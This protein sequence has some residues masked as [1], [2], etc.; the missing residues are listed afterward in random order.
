MIDWHRRRVC[1]TGGTGFL[2]FH[3][4]RQLRALGAQVRV[5]A[6]PAPP[7]HPIHDLEDVEA[8]YGDV[9]D[10][11]AVRQSVQGCEVIFHTAGTV[12]FWG[13]ALARLRNVH[14]GGTRN[15]LD[16]AEPKTRIVHTSS[17]VAVGTA[18][19]DTPATEETIWNLR[20]ARVDYIHAK[21]AAEKLA[22]DAAAKGQDVVVV[23][24]SFLVGPEDHEGSGLTRLCQRFWKGR[25]LLAPP[26]GMNLVDVR[27]VAAGHILAA[28]RGP[29]G[30]R[31]LLGGED[32]EFHQ[33]LRLLARVA[34][35]RPRSLPR[36]PQWCLLALARLS[37]LKARL[38]SRPPFPG[39]QEVRLNTYRWFCSSD[40]ARRELSYQP[41]SLVE[42]FADMHAWFL[43]RGRLN[44][45]GINRWW[46]RPA[47]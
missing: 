15:I 8:I 37:E 26:G 20:R 17:V 28:E 31:Y 38:N 36:L 40:R 25:V 27:D 7:Q 9:R 6:L 43:D 24:P 4:V 11:N 34:G 18:T 22:Q 44:L 41:R 29:S 13:P 2:G 35:L 23:N 14:V 39:V 45:R 3:L 19:A 42:S 30:R 5:L 47:A 46:M 10:L 12:A 16:C 32:L 21:R 33:M 1:V